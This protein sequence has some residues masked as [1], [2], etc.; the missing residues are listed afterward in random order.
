VPIDP[1]AEREIC[2]IELHSGLTK[3]QFHA[4]R[5]AGGAA[6]AR[7]PSFRV[8]PRDDEPGLDAPA[9][10]RALVQKLAAAG[11]VQTGAGPAPWDLRFERERLP[12]PQA[13]RRTR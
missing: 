4:V 9:A 13:P 10:L 7:S 12:S 8:K 6:L 11:W 5:Y 3:T 1:Q 2:W